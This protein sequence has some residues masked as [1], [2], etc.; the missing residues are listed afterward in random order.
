MKKHLL[1]LAVF[2]LAAALIHADELGGSLVSQLDTAVRVAAGNLNKKL[3][4]EKAGNVAVGQFSYR[5]TT[6]PLGSYWINQLTGELANIPNRAYIIL[7]GGP[8]GADWTISGEIIEVAAD[9]I[10]VYIRLI[11]TENRAVEASFTFDLERSEQ[12]NGMLFSAES[13][14]GRSSS[15][16]VPDSLEPDSFEHPIPYEIGV[17]DNALV[18]SRTLHYDDEDFFLLIPENGQLVMETTGSVDTFME[19]YDAE[20][21]ERLAQNDDGGSGGNARIRYNVQAGKRYIAKVRGYD[22][23]ETG[24]YG[25]RAYMQVQVMLAPDEYEPDND[26]ASAKQIEIGT[27]QQHTFHNSNDEDWVKFQI[28]QPGRYVIRARGIN[29]N[30]LDTYIELFDSNLNLIGND[31]DGGEYLDSR[32]SVYLQIGLYYLKAECFNENP[33]Q[34]YAIS[35]MN[36]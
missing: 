23:S 15:I 17:D 24:A 11:R 30:R 13:Q 31:D 5:G 10:R 33:D 28:T 16:V 8:A 1:A 36:E 19:F 32:M 12:I 25:F 22:S 26:A 7:S 21:R 9:T 34:P 2:I 6:V 35:I 18:I 4:E 3:I 20:T 27:S 14:G 29:S